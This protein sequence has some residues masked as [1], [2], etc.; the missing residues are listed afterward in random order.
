ME[1]V[2]SIDDFSDDMKSD[3]MALF[4]THF[5]KDSKLLNPKYIDWLYQA[6]PFGHAKAAYIV[7]EGRW[8]GFMALIPVLLR[9]DSEIRQAYFV[10]DVLVDPSHRGRNLFMRMITAAV[11]VVRHENAMLLGYPNA[12]ALK[13]WQLKKMHFQ[14]D[15][16]PLLAVPTPRRWTLS[17]STV[18]SPARLN[19]TENILSQVGVDADTWKVAATP[20]YLK[21]RFGDHPTN[22][23]NFQILR[24]GGNVVG[25]QIFRKLR[26]GLNLL[27]DQFVLDEFV[28]VGIAS[29]PIFTVAF[30][31]DS[32]ARRVQGLISLPVK[33]RLQFFM[34]S[35]N[36]PVSASSAANLMLSA[37][38]F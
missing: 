17:V 9:R 15:L 16:R 36:E 30:F 34:T 33:K 22:V 7:H 13:F 21:W 37:S 8:V 38:D 6:N 5:D 32:L 14:E 19:E 25:I 28:G 20:E 24:V 27:M 31:P 23:Y 4:E 2:T 26:T 10:V 29:L 18:V 35:F 1:Y 11:E 12:A 3:L